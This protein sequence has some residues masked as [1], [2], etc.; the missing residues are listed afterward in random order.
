[1][2]K[3]ILIADDDAMIMQIFT[4]GMEQLASDVHIHS[5]MTGESTISAIESMKPDVLVLDIRMPQGDGFT[6]LDYLK[7]QKNNM[8]V[9]VLTNYRDDEYVEKCRTYGVK[10]YLIKHEMKIDRIVERV[11]ACL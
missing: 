5:S 7:K 3:T 8:P 4:L 1:M 2:S 6:V 10:D 11:T 9:V